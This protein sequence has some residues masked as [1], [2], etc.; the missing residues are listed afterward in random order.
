MKRMRNEIKTYSEL[1]SFSTFEE[2]FKYLCL[3]GRVGVD[4]FGFERFLNQDFYHSKEWRQVRDH[5]IVRDYGCDLAVENHPIADGIPFV[6]HHMNPI[7]IYDIEHS[8]E[9]LLNPEYLVLTIKRTH[10]AIH[11]GDYNSFPKDYVPRRPNDT[12]PWK[13]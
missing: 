10:D 1:I 2:R 12:C 6:I 13:A 4:T 9:F 11:Y 7:E 8:T 3:H 5:I